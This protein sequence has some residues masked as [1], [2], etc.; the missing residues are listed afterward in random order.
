MIRTFVSGARLRAGVGRHLCV[1]ALAASAGLLGACAS[2]GSVGQRAAAAAA[3]GAGDLVVENNSWDRVTVYLERGGQLWRVGDV[4][5]L[6]KTRFSMKQ[7]GP[8]VDGR[9]TYLVA[10]PI[11]GSSFR[12]ESFLFPMGSTAVWTIENQSGLSHVV[13]R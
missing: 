7:L 8:L 12:S 13:V 4:G 3:G 11:A 5:A 1:I 9:N 10:H 2:S 6:D